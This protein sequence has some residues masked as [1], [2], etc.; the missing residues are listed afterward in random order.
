MERFEINDCIREEFFRAKKKHPNWPKDPIHA[1]A[2]VAEESGE[3]TQAALQFVYEGGNMAKMAK[4]AIHT[5]VTAIRFMEALPSDVLKECIDEVWTL[6][7]TMA[8]KGD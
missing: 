8:R 4:E 6:A 5:A 2:I 1:A 7:N 3:L